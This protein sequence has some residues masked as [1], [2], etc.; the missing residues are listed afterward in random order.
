MN[1]GGVKSVFKLTIPILVSDMANW[2]S[3][4]GF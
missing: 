4:I 3:H 1:G 2:K